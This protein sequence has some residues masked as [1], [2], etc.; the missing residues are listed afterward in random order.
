MKTGLFATQIPKYASRIEF[1]THKPM[2]LHLTDVFEFEKQILSPGLKAF[3]QRFPEGKKILSGL[4]PAGPVWV[5]TVN[6]NNGR[7][8]N[9][10][11]PL[12]RF[13]QLKQIRP[14]EATSPFLPPILLPHHEDWQKNPQDA[15][16]RLSSL[17]ELNRPLMKDS[18]IKAEDLWQNMF[19][20]CLQRVYEKPQRIAYSNIR[21][22]NTIYQ[23]IGF[24]Q[25]GELVLVK[26][27]T[28][29]S[30]QFQAP[31]NITGYQPHKDL[32]PHLRPP[33]KT[34]PNGQRIDFIIAQSE[35][36]KPIISEFT[37]A[38]AAFVPI[39]T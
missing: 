13:F 19:K 16:K 27:P 36:L 6:Y 3:V 7:K 30:D 28:W 22:K 31:L 34:T 14:Q 21:S 2:T 25:H 10:D 17:L 18:N 4:S 20:A 29:T 11:N 35:A 37:D 39:K 33:L 38:N 26:N 5:T 9:L 15:E 8:L 32:P 24:T 1:G 12:L 23:A